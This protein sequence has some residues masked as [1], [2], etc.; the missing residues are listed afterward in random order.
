MVFAMQQG[1]P[2][3]PNVPIL[4]GPFGTGK[5]HDAQ[6]VSV[7]PGTQV[8][9]ATYTKGPTAPDRG[10]TPGDRDRR[11]PGG[12]GIDGSQAIVAIGPSSQPSGGG[13]PA[14]EGAPAGE[15]PDGDT[16][17]VTAPQP[18]PKPA[19]SPA[20]SQ[21]V[22]NGNGRPPITAGVS[23]PSQGGGGQESSKV[24]GPERSSHERESPPSWANDERSSHERDEEGSTGPE[25]TDRGESESG[26]SQHER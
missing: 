14:G 18:A 3:A 24:R 9:G 6:V 20:P 23:N 13:G 17:P 8:G 4:Q 21:G 10:A 12:S 5:I 19:P 2:L 11:G 1:W 15:A 26:R 7:V 22:S 16:Q 25:A